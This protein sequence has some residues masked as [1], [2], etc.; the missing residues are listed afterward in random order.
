MLS[1]QSTR[2][3]PAELQSIG[4][5]NARS[6]MQRFSSSKTT[7]LCLLGLLI[8]GSP[9]VAFS[10]ITAEH[11][12]ELYALTKEIKEAA[13]AI[14]KKE[15]EAAETILKA[16]EEKVDEIATAA[17]LEKTNRALAGP[18][19]A[20]A[21]QRTVLERAMSGGKPNQVKKVSFVVDVAPLIDSKCL[22]CHGTNNPRAGLSLVN[23]AGWK[24]GGQAGPLLIP[25]SANQ[26]LIIARL[27]APEGQGQ[28]PQ[29]GGPLAR[30]EIETIAN[31]VNQG[32]AFDGEAENMTLADLIYE[33]EKKTLNVTIPKPKGGE[34][35]SF[36]KDIAPFM[37]NLCGGCHN[38][39]NKSGGL[40]L[41]SFYDMMKGGESGEVILPGDTENSRLFRLTGGL[42]LPRMPQGQARLTRTN[43]ENLKQ[44]FK[45]GNVYDGGDPRTP[46]AEFIRSDAEI[47]ADQFASMS[48]ADF[49]K[50]RSERSL[51][52]I[53]KAVPNDVIEQL[54]TDNFLLIG[55][56]NPARLEQV[57]GWADTQ[58]ETLH[59][60]FGGNGA[61]WKGR[62]AIFV[63]KDRFSYDEFNQVVE[64]RRAEAAMTG[65]SKVTANQEDAYIVLQDVGDDPGAHNLQISLVEHLSGAYLKQDGG[66]LPDWLVSGTGLKMAA[67]LV[68]DKQY[69]FQL[70][71]TA[72]EIVPTLG[73]PDDVFNDGSFSPSTI[74]P[75][76]FTLV[77]YLLNSAGPAKFAV[78]VKAFQQ[79]QDVNQAFQA[80]Y[81]TSS[82][83]VARAYMGSLK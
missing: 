10:Q 28:M 79:G 58:L 43:Y 24:K 76:G 78:L 36:T 30:E 2:V 21:L 3:I 35:V 71:K 75:V 17:G 33:H 27:M 29:R 52:Q 42:E 37:T 64:Q 69:T 11:K 41:V 40:S 50:H 1:H 53:K 59:K 63:M 56:A 9:Q 81:G 32:A 25:G 82:A 54:E 77:D 7:L 5:S 18:L 57:K 20:I 4:L 38:A 73:Q 31:W 45:E 67:A 19:K 22:G 16:A 14:R 44:W 23:F 65:H 55:N 48:E 80:A 66:T 72:A 12:K 13:T 34:T 74:G 47:M 46:M 26:S 15:Y 68:Q 61:P 49:K 83:N 70:R 51:E 60:M 6:P 39:R 62:L 8:F